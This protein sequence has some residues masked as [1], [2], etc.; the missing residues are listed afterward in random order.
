MKKL[1]A[2]LLV[3]ATMLSLTACGFHQGNPQQQEKALLEY[4][5]KYY[6]E[7][8]VVEKK[9]EILDTASIYT[10]KDKKDGF[11]Y[12]MTAMEVYMSDLGFKTAENNP[13]AKTIV[14]DGQFITKYVSNLMQNKVDSAEYIEFAESHKDTFM[15]VAIFE[16][17]TTAASLF[18]ITSDETAFLVP[19][20]DAQTIREC[21]AM[22][23]KYDER[24]ILNYYMMPIYKGVA[25]E[26]GYT[27]A[28]NAD[29]TA[30]VLG[31]YDFF[32]DYV[33]KP[34]EFDGV[35]TLHDYLVSTE[36]AEKTLRVQTV[37]VDIPASS[38][39]VAEGFS[40]APSITQKGTFIILY[41]DDVLYEFYTLL[42]IKEF[43]SETDEFGIYEGSFLH[44]LHPER[45]GGKDVLVASYALTY[46]NLYT[47]LTLHFK[48]VESTSQPAPDID[49]TPVEPE[50]NHTTEEGTE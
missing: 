34:E 39:K 8:E 11:L 42:G 45:T 6:G 37:S 9:N 27:A 40:F 23:R 29:G 4:V 28:E 22:M 48:P 30:I 3:C 26:T 38:I 50:H 2:L 7:A 24:G 25:T 1:I 44:M 43:D 18:A 41:V 35:A 20:L 36:Y 16:R 21:A 12:P 49:P 13:D 10:L 32:L 33:M 5:A 31:Y 47:N 15:D 46:S 19:S 14:F 17:E